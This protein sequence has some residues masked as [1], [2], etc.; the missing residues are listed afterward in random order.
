MA[1]G[2]PLPRFF[3]QAS[4]KSTLHE[5]Q[6]LVFGVG[7]AASTGFSLLVIVVVVVEMKKPPFKEAASAIVVNGGC[8]GYQR[9]PLLL[10]L[11]AR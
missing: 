5:V 3:I 7:V 8:A 11:R 9:L 1:A 2:F 6:H 10:P 4:G